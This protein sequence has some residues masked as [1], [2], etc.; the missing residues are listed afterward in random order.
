MADLA[1]TVISPWPLRVRLHGGRNTHAAR[2][3]SGGDRVTACGYT[4][5]E[6][7]SNHWLA[8]D[9]DMT[10]RD[11]AHRLQHPRIGDPR[12]HTP[13]VDSINEEG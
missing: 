11:C 7:A 6:N 3:I 13:D 1:P 9:A 4:L 8:N 5:A 10:C 12:Q 2:I